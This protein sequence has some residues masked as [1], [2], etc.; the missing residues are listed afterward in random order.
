MGASGGLWELWEGCGSFG[1]VV[2]ASG[3]MWELQEGCWS[4]GKVV[5]A[6]AEHG[7]VA[8]RKRI[9]AKCQDLC[10]VGFLGFCLSVKIV[11]YQ[12]PPSLRL[13]E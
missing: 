13:D 1:R 7:G 3:G 5:G 4:F 6:L 8:H 12:N 9:L 11:C 10:L 2:G